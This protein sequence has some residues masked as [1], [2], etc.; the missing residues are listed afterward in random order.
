MKKLITATLATI[1]STSAFAANKIYTTN[2]SPVVNNYI[3]VALAVPYFFTI[4]RDLHEP[5]RTVEEGFGYDY[6]YDANRFEPNSPLGLRAVLVSKEKSRKETAKQ[7]AKVLLPGDVVLSYRKEWAGTGP[8]PHIQLGVSHSSI[9]F[10]DDE[11]YARNLDLPLNEDYVQDEIDKGP[12]YFSS[13]HYRETEL[14]HVIR[15]RLNATQRENVNQWAKLL[16]KGARANYVKPKNQ[17][18]PGQI[19]FNTDYLK[20]QIKGKQPAQYL[21]GAF[22]LGR[23][24][25]GYGNRI[26]NNTMFCS[27]LAW[28]ILSMR[29]CNPTK[30][31]NDFKGTARPKCLADRK[32]EI[33]PPL[34]L[35][36]NI[37]TEP[38]SA[39]ARPG[40]VDGPMMLLQAY[41]PQ[42]PMAAIDS[43]FKEDNRQGQ[44]SSGH[45]AVS[46]ALPPE[47][48]AALKQYFQAVVVSPEQA[49][50]AREAITAKAIAMGF[51]ENYAPASFVVNALLPNNHDEKAM[52][53]AFTI[54]YVDARTLFLAQETIDK[55]LSYDDKK[56]YVLKR[57]PTPVAA[58][59]SPVVRQALGSFDN[60][61]TPMR[62]KEFCENNPSVEFCQQIV[63]TLID[64]NIEVPYANSAE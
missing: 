29:D 43:I 46:N 15:P 17:I 22:N 33:F 20:P 11:G 47:L 10:I 38:N 7:L 49:A 59:Y 56:A 30:D 53:Y 61:P 60:L 62:K 58:D 9:A 44:M 5:M 55:K 27:E 23:I 40:M 4:P 42:D 13:N 3:H 41:K 52:D 28:A 39:S 21:D 8:Y 63:Q 14:L 35:L 48:F 31:A 51:S 54:G 64:N 6:V 16:I 36:G 26:S 1:L 12:S 24:A 18:Y 25:L 19:G 32:A 34:P 37:L 50:M 45:N 2:D 57:K